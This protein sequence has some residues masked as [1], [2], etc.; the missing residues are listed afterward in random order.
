MRQLDYFLLLLCL[1]SFG[2]LSAE[3]ESP[4]PLHLILKGY[5]SEEQF[6]SA[7]DKLAAAKVAPAALVLEI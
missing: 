6:K 5:L 1:L 7:Q 2:L 4:K 3:Q